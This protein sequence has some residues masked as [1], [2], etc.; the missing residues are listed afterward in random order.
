MTDDTLQAVRCVPR[1]TNQYLFTVFPIN[2]V[3]FKLYPTSLQSR[4]PSMLFVRI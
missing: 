4:K 2:L 3:I 1:A